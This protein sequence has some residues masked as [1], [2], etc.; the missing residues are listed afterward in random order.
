MKR[1]VYNSYLLVLNENLN[2]VRHFYMTEISI[3]KSQC[4]W[5]FA[6]LQVRVGIED[7]NSKIFILFLNGNICCDPSLEPPRQDG[8]NDGSQNI[9]LM[10]NVAN[11]P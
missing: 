6:E 9:F 1:H 4:V 10:K 3:I 2:A 11:Y 7:N 5:P 8:S